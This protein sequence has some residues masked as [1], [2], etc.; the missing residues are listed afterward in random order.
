MFS[1][2]DLDAILGA[3][4]EDITITLSGVTVKTVRGK[5]RRDYQNP[6]GFDGVGGGLQPALLLK[7]SDLTGITAGH[8]FL[9]RGKA[10]VHDGKPQERN[11]GLT[12]VPLGVKL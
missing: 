7:T 11:D 5:F 9:I 10:Y 1:S 3:A 2:A 12:L 6:E 4:G 8:A